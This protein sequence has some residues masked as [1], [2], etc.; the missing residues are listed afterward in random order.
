MEYETHISVS[1][2]NTKSAKNDRNKYEH[3]IKYRTKRKYA[4][5]SAR[6]SE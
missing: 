3:M 5:K 1:N 6:V 4:V 2:G